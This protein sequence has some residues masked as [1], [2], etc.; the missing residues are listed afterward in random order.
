L[1]LIVNLPLPTCATDIRSF[2]GHVGFYQRFIKGFSKVAKL[3]FS[4][5]AKDT[6][7]HFSKECEVAFM[8]L[9]EALTMAPI[10]H[11][12]VWEESFE[13]M[14]DEL[15]YAVGVVLQQRIDKKSHV[16]YYAS[17]TL[18]EAQVNDIVTEKDFFA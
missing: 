14:Y 13:L 9:N 6:S 11:P 8:K 16:I 3:L 12:P 4:L 10:L 15:D 17:H 18:N 7:F 2:L 5:L 1:D